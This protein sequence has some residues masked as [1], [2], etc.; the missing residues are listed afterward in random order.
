MPCTK[1]LTRAKPSHRAPEAPALVA[2][3]GDGVAHCVLRACC[4]DGSNALSA[5]EAKRVLHHSWPPREYSRQA[6]RYTHSPPGCLSDTGVRSK[7]FLNASANAPRTV[8]VC[9]PVASQIWRTV[10]PS[11]RWRIRITRACWPFASV[12]GFGHRWFGRDDA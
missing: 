5:G 1:S 6:T 3:G 2:G 4:D 8:W 7:F 11:G 10:A 9:Q 12:R